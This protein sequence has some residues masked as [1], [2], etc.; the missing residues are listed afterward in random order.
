MTFKLVAATDTNRTAGEATEL[1]A[2]NPSTGTGDLDFGS[3]QYLQTKILKFK[4][5]N[6]GAAKAT[7]T[8]TIASINTDLAT[9][10]TLSTDGTTYST[11]VVVNV[12]ANR[13]SKVIYIKHYVDISVEDTL[14]DGSIK[15][16]VVES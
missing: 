9:N 12:D 3:I 10:T 2:Y 6:T 1:T 13:V 15:I 4:I 7:F 11:S 8:V 5:A 14:G 16:K